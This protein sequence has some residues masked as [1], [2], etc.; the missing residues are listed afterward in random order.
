MVPRVDVSVGRHQQLRRRFGVPAEDRLASV[1]TISASPAIVAAARITCSS[2]ARF[3]A[4]RSPGGLAAIGQVIGYIKGK[5]AI[6][7]A[8][9]FF[10]QERNSVG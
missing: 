1:T 3:K 7:V 9:T 2:C 8:G 5:S 4:I 10:D 6:H